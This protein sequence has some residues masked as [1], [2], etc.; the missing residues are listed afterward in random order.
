M[1]PPIGILYHLRDKYSWHGS[2]DKDMLE[3]RRDR[4]IY[5]NDK[6]EKE[7]AAYT[8]SRTDFHR[9]NSTTFLITTIDVDP[10]KANFEA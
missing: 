4:R 2:V 3:I 5:R 10:I 8:A 7:A 6:R 1:S 9:N